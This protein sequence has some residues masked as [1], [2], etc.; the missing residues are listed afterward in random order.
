MVISLNKSLENTDDIQA[1]TIE[2]RLTSLV[3]HLPASQREIYGNS[4]HLDEMK[5]QTQMVSYL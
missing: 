4:G 3:M 1:E 2:A 5:V